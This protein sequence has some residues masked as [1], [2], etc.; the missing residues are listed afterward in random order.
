MRTIQDSLF[1]ASGIHPKILLETGSIEVEKKVCLACGA[2][3]LCP[4]SYLDDIRAS[5][6]QASIYPV[7][8]SATERALLYLPQKRTVPDEIYA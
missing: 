8:N 3:M 2:V 5:G 7:L 4:R 6:C 1:I